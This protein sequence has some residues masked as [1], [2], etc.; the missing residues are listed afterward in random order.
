MTTRSYLK[1]PKLHDLLEKIKE[2]NGF[3]LAD[4]SLYN[5]DNVDL[6][7]LK[8]FGHVDYVGGKHDGK[9]VAID[10]TEKETK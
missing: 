4:I 10:T 7:T 8:R 2:H 6:M 3:T 9:W 1:C 5:V